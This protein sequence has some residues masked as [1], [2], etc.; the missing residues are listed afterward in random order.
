MDPTP[1]LYNELVAE[2]MEN[3]AEASLM[4]VPAIA[5]GARSM[6]TRKH[7]AEEDCWLAY[8]AQI[9]VKPDDIFVLSLSSVLLSVLPD[10]DTPAV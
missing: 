9:D 3:L 7:T 10:D 5:N 4:L 8:V 2:S 6:S 1:R